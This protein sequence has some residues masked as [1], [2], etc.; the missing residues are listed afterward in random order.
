MIFE[1]LPARI[2]AADFRVDAEALVEQIIARGKTPVLVGGTML[3]FKALLEGMADMPAAD[4][5]IRA[6]IEQLA[7][8]QGWPAVHC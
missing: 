2:G 1:T 7:Q 4:P 8:Q 6:D 5:A 3:Y